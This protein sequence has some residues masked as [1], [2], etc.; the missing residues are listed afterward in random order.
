MSYILAI[1]QG[2]SS[3]RAALVDQHGQIC[4][5][6][7]KEFTQIFP[8]ADWVEHD[9]E[10]IWIVQLDVIKQVIEVS[11]IELDQIAGVGITNQRETT[12][13]WDKI[14]G[15]PICNAIVW[16]DKRTADYCLSI[17]DE[18]QDYFKEKTGLPVDPYFSGT[19]LKWILDKY[20]RNENLLFGTIDTWLIWKMTEGRSHLTDYTNASRTLLYNIRE[21]VWDDKIL[22]LF[23]IPINMLPQ[24]QKSASDFGHFT[25]AGNNIPITGVAG[26]Q[27]AA[28]FGQACFAPGS[29]KN[30]YGTGCFMLMNIGPE[31][32][33]SKNGLI[34][35]L[36]CDEEGAPV[37]ALEG[38]IFVA[39]AAVQWLRDGLK[40]VAKSEETESMAESVKDQF[41]ITVIPA[42]S[43]LG[44]P[45]WKS[46]ARAAI[47]GL[48]R[49]TTADHLA[50]ATLD[51]IAFRTKDVI[52]A[53][54]KDSQ[55]KISSLSVDGGATNNDYL[56]QF[57]A[58]IL[59]CQIN[60]PLNKESTV[61]GAAYLA[62]IELGIW[63]TKI[64]EQNRKI[65]KVFEPKMSMK[66]VES[67]Y[68]YWKQMV[69]HTLNQPPKLNLPT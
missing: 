13:V 25:L 42:F 16:Q 29:V 61:M 17:K 9:A 65:E 45:Y 21:K 50:K 2:T 40:I 52:N 47:Y 57:Q 46:D 23:D 69:A 1:D 3:C 36:C 56:M 33:K 14:T 38:S 49:A 55:L 37:Y 7:Q 24:V 43:G 67:L 63:G 5:V 26:D 10:E 20:G 18:Y 6:A 58:D 34:T 19:K 32:R 27:Q 54:I 8:N 53:M 59:E 28:L 68:Q 39:G 64:I 35:T 11:N 15:K 22:Q 31:F 66:K 41:D 48:T 62:G 30:T 60:R 44:A 51:A 4:H 12:V